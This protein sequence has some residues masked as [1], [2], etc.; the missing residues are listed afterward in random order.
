ME[1]ANT[2]AFYDTATIAAVK[3]F[4][5][6]APGANVIKNTAVIL[7]LL[8]LGLNCNGNLL[9]NCSVL[10]PFWVKLCFITLV[11]EILW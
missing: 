9:P 5:A 8:F 2:L 11:T 1:V 4:I 10:L 7:T 6:Q 3:S